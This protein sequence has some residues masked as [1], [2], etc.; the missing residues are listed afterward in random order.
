M[1]MPNFLTDFLSYTVRNFPDKI[2]VVAGETTMTWKDIDEKSN[3][4]ANALLDNGIKRGDRVIVCLDNC[5]E[6]VIL[7]WAILKIKAVISILHPATPMVQLNW[8]LRDSAANIIFM[9]NYEQNISIW[10]RGCAEFIDLSLSSNLDFKFFSDN[11]KN[12]LSNNFGIDLDLAAI[13]YTSG[14]T[15]LPKGVMLTHRN[16]VVAAISI[17]QYLDLNFK[18]IVIS[19]LPLSF[20]YGL[21]QIILTTLI[22]AKL[23]LEK[24]FIWPLQFLKKIQQE[25]ATV[26]P[27]VTTQFAILAKYFSKIT[28]SYNSIRIIT[29]TGAALFMHHV[30]VLNKIFPLTNIF[31]MYGL[32]ECKRCT[33]LPPKDLLIKPQSVGVAIPNT[34][35]WIIDDDGNKLPP[36]QVGQLVVRGATIMLGYWNNLAETQKI[37]RD[38]DLPGEKILYTGDYGYLDEVGYFYLSGRRDDIIKRY[39]EKVSLKAIEE[40]IRS[41]PS[42]LAVAAIHEAE[43]ITGALI[44]VFV[45]KSDLSISSDQLMLYCKENLPRSHWPSA[46]NFVAE[47]PKNLNGKYDRKKLKENFIS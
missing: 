43:E 31:S 10:L 29:N 6:T 35:I 17:N 16:M 18:D 47:L 20:D 2:A 36:H 14:S 3:C 9:R 11:K 19:A 40:V 12:I 41:F 13:I 30:E 5:I 34:E 45:E 8:I 27:G 26:F 15:G 33:Y 24:D 39:G 32:T 7:F 28:D 23:I 21:Y 1:F 22:G 25:G 4:L 44:I 42:I 46:I 37:L 38:G